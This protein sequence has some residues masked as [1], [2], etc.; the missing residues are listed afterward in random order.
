[1]KQKWRLLSLLFMYTVFC[2]FYLS[3]LALVSALACG[4]DW[5]L[6]PE[7]PPE[8][9]WEDKMCQKL[10]AVT[11]SCLF[12]TVNQMNRIEPVSRCYIMFPSC[13][14]LHDF[15]VFLQ[16][17]TPDSFF[18]S[19]KTYVFFLLWKHAVVL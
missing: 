2:L 1:M 10:S 17:V 9:G 7:M 5:V 3:Y 14:I 4:A 11:Q 16:G 19:K 18:K 12:P 13:L 8:D 6:I 15:S